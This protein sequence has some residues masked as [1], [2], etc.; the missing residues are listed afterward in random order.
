MIGERPA[1][2][3]PKST[4]N[5]GYQ[6]ISAAAVYD[7]RN[8]IT[9]AKPALIERSHDVYFSTLLEAHKRNECLFPVVLECG[10]VGVSLPAPAF[11]PAS[12]LAVTQFRGWSPPAGGRRHTV[13]TI[14]QTTPCD[15]NPLG[16]RNNLEPEKLCRLR[17]QRP[18]G[19]R[20]SRWI[21]HL[22]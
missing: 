11:M 22:R 1:I 21:S 13:H 12:L 6:P 7:R 15:E 20:P 19:T 2:E 17:R 18:R 5:R 9:F 8:P 10:S 16:N 3:G 14:K 4:F